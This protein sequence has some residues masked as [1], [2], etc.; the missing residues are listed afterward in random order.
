MEHH[1]PLLEPEEER[2][3][4]QAARAGDRR[5]LEYL[6]RANRPYVLKVAGDYRGRGVAFEDLVAEGNLGLLE[7]AP[8]YE[9]ARGTRFLTYATWWIRKRMLAALDGQARTVRVPGRFW[10]SRGKPGVRPAPAVEIRLH[11]PDG[12]PI[13]EH[14]RDPGALHAEQALVHGESL[15]R[16]CSAVARLSA[17]ERCVL[18]H[19]FGLRGE[20]PRTL[21]ETGAHLRLSRER[22]R[23][24][25]QQAIARLKR[26]LDPRYPRPHVRPRA[27]A[28][29]RPAASDVAV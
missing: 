9:P 8:R 11:G 5:A 14:L 12:A 15:R 17:Q 10:P 6:L 20:E 27:P 13:V 2:V 25:E 26:A 21:Q 3:L 1:I 23:Q 16:M 22:V 4:L 28:P 29:A 18:D 24:V 19:R 7:A